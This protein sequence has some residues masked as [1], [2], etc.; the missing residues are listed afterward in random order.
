MALWGWLAVCLGGAGLLV[1]AVMMAVILRSVRRLE[2]NLPGAGERKSLLA[3][4][5]DG[6]CDDLSRLI[7]GRWSDI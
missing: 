1:L 2:M 4:A 7:L 6:L 5:F 3:A